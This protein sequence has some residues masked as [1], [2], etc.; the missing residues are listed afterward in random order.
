MATLGLSVS[1]DR[2]QSIQTSIAQNI[3]DQ[4]QQMNSVVPLTLEKEKFTLSAIDNLDQNAKLATAQTHFHGTA[5]SMFQFGD[6]SVKA[7]KRR[8]LENFA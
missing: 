5:I 2:V 8:G 1:Y 4:F 6:I 7:A 3:C